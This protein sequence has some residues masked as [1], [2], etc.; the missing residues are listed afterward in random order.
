MGQVHSQGRSQACE[1]TCLRSFCG[2]GKDWNF[3]KS[4]NA[5]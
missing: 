5:I 4:K 2:N 3:E 1:L